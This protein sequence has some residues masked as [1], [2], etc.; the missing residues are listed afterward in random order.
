MEGG[1]EEETP[2]MRKFVRKQGRWNRSRRKEEKL[3][4]R[5]GNCACFEKSARNPS[6]FFKIHTETNP[7]V[8]SLRLQKLPEITSGETRPEFQDR[9]SDTK[10][11]RES[12]SLFSSEFKD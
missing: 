5:R 8:D 1:R 9:K 11:N 10:S 12:K 7:T 6:R 2:T 4:I 3:R